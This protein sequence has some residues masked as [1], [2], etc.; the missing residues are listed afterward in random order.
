MRNG[1][2]SLGAPITAPL[3]VNLLILDEGETGSRRRCYRRF[4]MLATRLARA[5]QGGPSCSKTF[6][7]PT[8]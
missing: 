8:L 6:S 7:I 3:S 4:S 5:P 1:I 2:G